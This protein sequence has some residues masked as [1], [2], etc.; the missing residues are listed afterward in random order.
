[1]DWAG[2]VVEAIRGQRLGEVMAQR[3]FAPWA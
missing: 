2:L 3:V 1:M